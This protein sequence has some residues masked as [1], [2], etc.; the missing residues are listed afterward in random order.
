MR[1]LLLALKKGLEADLTVE[2]GGRR[3]H[4]R[5]D[6]LSVTVLAPSLPALFHFG[7]LLWP[8]RKWAPAQA[9]I[10]GN[11]VVVSAPDVPI[12]LA[13]R[14]AWENF[15]T[16]NLSNGAGLPASPFRTDEWK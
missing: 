16:C 12:P 6:G 5:A 4:F 13:A 11:T 1:Q 9:R 10:V 3:I 2:H 15:P 7:L 14:Y 8:V